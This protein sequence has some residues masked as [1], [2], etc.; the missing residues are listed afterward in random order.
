M[1]R[2]VLPDDKVAGLRHL[3]S[4]G[5][6]VPPFA[7]MKASE[8]NSHKARSTLE[9]LSIPNSVG[10]RIG[11]VVRCSSS[12]KHPRDL[13]RSPLHLQDPVEII[14]WI[15]KL[16]GIVDEDDDLILQHVVDARASGTILADDKV[17]V[18]VI[19]GDAPELLEGRSRGNET[20]TYNRQGSFS[21]WI[22][23]SQ[24]ILHDNDLEEFESVIFKLPSK[25]YLEWSLS[26][27]GILYCYEYDD[28]NF[29][30][31][32][33]EELPR[34]LHQRCDFVGLGACQGEGEGILRLVKSSDDF[35]RIQKGDIVVIQ[36]AGREFS[37][38]LSNVSAVVTENGGI[39]SHGAILAREYGVPC[40]VQVKDAL[41]VL[42]DGRRA[43]V[44][45]TRGT[46]TLLE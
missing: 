4:L 9:R 30:M 17:I 11:L 6:K 25:A 35:S 22:E 24:R 23:G 15:I 2:S 16:A 39:T 29:L 12:T 26:K 46:V 1:A 43:L 19:T 37:S 41:K 28:F 7:V 5:L 18:E 32:E 40:V 8:A 3:Q 44:D 34:K 13:P 38:F 21:L 33:F 27:I 36:F 20:W 42:P 31:G 10:D 14:T 45:G